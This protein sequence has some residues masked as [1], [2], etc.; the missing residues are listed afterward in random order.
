MI[1]DE[2][3]IN[4]IH[5]LEPDRS[6]ALEAIRREALA[7]A[8][9]IIRDE[10]AALLRCFVAAFRPERILE[11][12]TAVGYSALCMAEAMPADARIVTIESYEPR[13]MKARE[14]LWNSPYGDRITIADKDASVVLEQLLAAGE[15]FDLVFLDAAKA[16]YP[17]WLPTILKLMAPGAVLLSDNILQEGSLA[18]SRFLIDRRERTIHSRMRE[19]LF[20]LQH[21]P[22]LTTAILPV[23]DG[24]SMSVKKRRENIE[25]NEE[26]CSF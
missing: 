14:N 1:T 10:T 21:H 24:I 11:I 15:H 25:E 6:P 18:E 9:P 17:V 26:S 5:S 3:L 23:G 20:T 7:A 22:E 19:Y 2:R 13:V 4:F 12:G 8:V 16:Q